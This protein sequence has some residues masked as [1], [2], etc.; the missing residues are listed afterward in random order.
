MTIFSKLLKLLRLIQIE[1]L[2]SKQRVTGSSPV[3]VAKT[4][5]NQ[6]FQ[7]DKSL[8][9]L[10]FEVFGNIPLYSKRYLCIPIPLK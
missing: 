3:G 5:Q 7:R 1:H 4:Q 6:G 9:V 8:K 10:V 2:P